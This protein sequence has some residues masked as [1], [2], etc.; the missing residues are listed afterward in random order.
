MVPKGAVI[1]RMEQDRRALSVSIPDRGG[2]LGVGL[3][4]AFYSFYLTSVK[5][6]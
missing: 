2:L 1:R 6:A 5:S 4:L 3:S